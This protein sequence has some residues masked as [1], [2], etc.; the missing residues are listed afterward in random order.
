MVSYYTIWYHIIQY[1]IIFYNMV[2]Y[3]TISYHIVQY[4][5]ILYNIILYYNIPQTVLALEGFL[6]LLYSN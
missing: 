6:L 2:S 1:G 5:I 4:D 3:Y